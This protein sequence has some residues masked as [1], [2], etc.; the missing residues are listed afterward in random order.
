MSSQITVENMTVEDARENLPHWLNA[1]AIQEHYQ[2]RGVNVDKEY[3]L[4]QRTFELLGKDEYKRIYDK[5]VKE[6]TS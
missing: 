5:T 6:A 3:D 2:F 1:C 4:T